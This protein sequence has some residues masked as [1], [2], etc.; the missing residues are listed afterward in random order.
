MS[1]IEDCRAELPEFFQGY[2]SESFVVYQE[3][4]QKTS[5]I[6]IDPEALPIAS[7]LQSE[8]I[9]A[10]SWKDVQACFETV[11]KTA[12]PSFG[13]AMMT[14]LFKAQMQQQV[15]QLQHLLPSSSQTTEE[16]GRRSVQ[17]AKEAKMKAQVLQQFQKIIIAVI[18][19]PN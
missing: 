17:S 4:I 11:K 18:T 14:M 7:T 5:F 19:Q 12:S 15:S 10:Q 16:E 2:V 8:F 3:M 1:I 13:A 9:S 6:D